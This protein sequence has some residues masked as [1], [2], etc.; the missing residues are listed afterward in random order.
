V[1]SIPI[2]CA[3]SSRSLLLPIGL[4]VLALQAT[5][6]KILLSK[7]SAQTSS[8]PP[9]SLP[10]TIKSL[11]KG[12]YAPFKHVE[13]NGGLRLFITLLIVELQGKPFP[14][15]RFSTF[16]D[17]H[18]HHHMTGHYLSQKLGGRVFLDL[19]IALNLDVV[20]VYP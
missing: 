17:H 16:R 5:M 3:E 19:F 10:T 2:Q 8:P 12:I 4:L 9:V 14:I 13:F 20:S 11:W 1:G 6:F 18:L 7:I 15:F